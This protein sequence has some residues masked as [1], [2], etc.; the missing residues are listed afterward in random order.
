MR[1]LQLVILAAALVFAVGG[2]WL[3]QRNST[4]KEDLK[5]ELLASDKAVMGQEIT[6]TV[7]WK[8]NG[9]V[10]LENAIVI[11]EYPENSLPSQGAL[12]RATKQLE[13]IYPGQEDSLAFKVRLF[14]AEGDIKEAKVM[15]SYKPRNLNARYEAETSATT[16]IS[17][18]PL[19]FDLD[20]P[21][22]IE[23][24]QQFT[25]AL[26]YFSNSD[27]PLSDLKIE[28]EYPQGFEFA[29][30]IPASLGDNEWRVPLLNK[31]QGGRISVKGTLRGELQELKTIRAT[32]GTWKDGK[33]TLLKESLKGV[34]ITKPEIRISQL[35]Q[36]KETNAVSPGDTLHY[37]IF[38]RN[39]S[40]RD[41]EN[42]FL[43]VGLEGKSFDVSTLRAENGKFQKGD[44]SVVWEARDVAKLR[45][46]GQGEEGKVEFWVALQNIQ[47][48][49]LVARDKVLL[50]EA[51]AEFEVK[52]SSNLSI[53][54]TAYFQDEVFGNSG[55]LPPTV[56]NKTTYTVIWK[57]QNSSNEVKNSKVK[58]TLPQGVELTGRLFPENA[59]LTFDS[60][61]R[62]IVWSAG[63]LAA[64]TGLSSPPAS[65]AFQIALTP[66]SSQRGTAPQILGQ[67]LITGDD[68]WT[69]QSLSSSDV[70]LDTTLP[71][72]SAS[73]EKGVV[74]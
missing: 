6:Y 28:I 10:A 44:N 38:F 57:V 12:L 70:P 73:Q 42:L 4:S 55:P 16:I 14:G 29:E 39:V 37:A 64:G 45:L 2:F 5:L 27:Y 58:A 63:D 36:G 25:F 41:L 52:V 26:N 31:T 65:V 69:L 3:W 30:A 8:N 67:A 1:N 49:N 20:L 74:Q 21:S 18:V 33:F 34:E 9:D 22:R 46:L 53:D 15:L 62:E 19:N 7:K 66:N 60:Q 61:S 50:S 59:S 11:F 17:L 47:G 43:I 48:K 72:D 68:T 71:D 56:G 54:Q 51:R 13:D 24:N 40:E 35:I 32:I 23:S